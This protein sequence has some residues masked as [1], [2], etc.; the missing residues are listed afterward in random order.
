[1]KIS[2]ALK[3]RNKSKEHRRKISKSLKGRNKSKEINNL[4]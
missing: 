3:G 4:G 1:R 2:E